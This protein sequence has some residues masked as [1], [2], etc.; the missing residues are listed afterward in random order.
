LGGVI[1]DGIDVVDGLSRGADAEYSSIRF[2]MNRPEGSPI[3]NGIKWAIYKMTG[4]GW[5][6]LLLAPEDPIDTGAPQSKAESRQ[7]KLRKRRSK[8][9][10]KFSRLRQAAMGIPKE[11]LS[12]A[13]IHDSE[14]N[15]AKAA[16]LR[17]QA[18]V[19]VLAINDAFDQM[20]AEA[21]NWLESMHQWGIV[22][23]RRAGKRPQ[24][25]PR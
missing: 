2:E 19:A 10:S 14:G 5:R 9:T 11:M 21:A 24:D 7:H 18:K 25:T 4:V 13:D 22:G 16:A 23:S 6:D 8:A 3:F 20:E 12:R 15:G 1:A 17:E